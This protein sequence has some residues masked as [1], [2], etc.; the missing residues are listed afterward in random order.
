MGTLNTSNYTIGG[1]NLYYNKLVGHDNIFSTNFETEANSLGN[2]VMA[3]INLDNSYVDHLKSSNGRNVKDKSFALSSTVTIPFIVDEITGGNVTKFVKGSGTNKEVALIT[4][5]GSLVID[6]D[7]EAGVTTYWDSSGVGL[8]KGDIGKVTEPPGEVYR[9]TYA[10]RY[11]TPNSGT[12]EYIYN[13]YSDSI[14]DKVYIPVGRNETF[15][16][17]IYA[18]LDTGIDSVKL[19]IVEYDG[20]FTEGD[21][22]MLASTLGPSSYVH[23]SGTY[24]TSLTTEAEYIVIEIEV[25]FTTGGNYLYIDNVELLRTV[26]A[27]YGSARL[28]VT[29]SVGR[30]VT[31]AIPK[32]KIVPDGSWE[33]KRDAWHELPLKLE[34]FKYLFGEAGGPVQNAACLAAPYGK[35]TVS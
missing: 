28:V 23:M 1:C 24:S 17:S 8:L 10:L 11:T 20:D 30:S 26:T 19:N 3:D 5:S 4:D 34:V 16:A 27:D 12:Q 9:G 2:I 14:T 13:T 7:M 21:R 15:T 33:M 22:T 31:Y 18:F 6:S 25:N 35:I 29:T 32:C